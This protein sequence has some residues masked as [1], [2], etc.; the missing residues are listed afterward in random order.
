M[1]SLMSDVRLHDLR[2]AHGSLTSKGGEGILANGRLLGHPSAETTL[3][4]THHA[5]S[6]AAEAAAVVGAVLAFAVL[7]SPGSGSGVST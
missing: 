5:V 1:P 4:Y 3:Q 2:H 6:L 7:I